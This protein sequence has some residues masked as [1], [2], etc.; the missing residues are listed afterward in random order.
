MQINSF[1]PVYLFALNFPYDEGGADGERGVLNDILG[2][3]GYGLATGS[4]EGD[5]EDSYIVTADA[6]NA[7]REELEALW[8]DTDQDAVLFLDNQRNACLYT[9]EDGYR[10]GPGTKYLGVFKEVNP[11]VVATLPGWTKIGNTYFAA[12]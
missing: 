5:E 10:Q 11:T 3:G 12:R 4:W 9:R 7:V 8:A 1:T 2:P 6:V